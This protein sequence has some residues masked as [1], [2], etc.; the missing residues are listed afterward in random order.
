MERRASL[1]GWSKYFI[2]IF[3][4]VSG[5]LSARQFNAKMVG[6]RS[7]P[8]EENENRKINNHK[9]ED[10]W[11]AP[12]KAKHFLTGAFSTIFI[13][14]TCED[15]KEMDKDDSKTY[16]VSFSAIISVGKEI[17]DARS[18]E[19]HFCKK[20]LLFDGLGILAGI[21]IINQR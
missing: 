18:A 1:M 21:I 15:V 17:I 9:K 12:D 10:K 14:K 13:Y 19:N 2:L 5:V 6:P 3:F 11:L 16:A 7:V 20:D 8:V 4:L